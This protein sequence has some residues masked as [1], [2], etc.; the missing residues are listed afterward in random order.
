LQAYRSVEWRRDRKRLARL[1][2]ICLTII[3]LIGTASIT[4]GEAAGQQ[5]PTRF[6][7]LTRNTIS[8]LHLAPAGTS[9]WGPNQCKNDPD[10][11]V[12]TDER[13]PITGTSSGIYDAKL[14]DRSG[15]VCVVRNINVEA[16][17]VFSID[18]KDLESCNH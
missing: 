1:F 18:E 5:R 6:W 2:A 15:R 14:T 3:A 10:G 4:V 12:D 8:E 13:L 16:G 7:N 9:N 11:A 17:K